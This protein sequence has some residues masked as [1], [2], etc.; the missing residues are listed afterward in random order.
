MGRQEG[1]SFSG[2]LATAVLVAIAAV[3][4]LEVIPP[5]L[6]YRTIRKDM[7]EVVENP[8]L[9]NAASP[10]IREAFSKKALIDGIKSVSAEDLEIKRAPFRLHVD[11]DAKVPLVLNFGAYFDFD[12][13]VVKGE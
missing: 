12:I 6:E 3:V 11:Y 9:S 5:Y 2:F 1:F 13:T 8:D 10:E 4:F 7:K